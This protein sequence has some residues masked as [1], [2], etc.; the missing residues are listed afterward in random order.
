MSSLVHH[1][2]WGA[3]RQEL[4]PKE[5][6]I[7]DRC[8]HAYCPKHAV[9]LSILAAYATICDKAVTDVKDRALE[10]SGTKPL[11][12]F[13]VNTVRS[14]QLVQ[15]EMLPSQSPES[16]VK[17]AQIMK[18]SG[19][20]FAEYV[21]CINKATQLAHAYFETKGHPIFLYGS[22]KEQIVQWAKEVVVDMA[23]AAYLSV[24]M[25]ASF[26]KVSF[27]EE[28]LTFFGMKD[29]KVKVDPTSLSCVAFALLKTKEKRAVDL[30]FKE[31]PDRFLKNLIEHLTEWNYRPVSEPDEGDLV[32]Y[33]TNEN[34]VD[35]VGYL[36]AEGVVHSKIGI[37][38]PFSHHHKI[39]SIPPGSATVLFFRK[40]VPID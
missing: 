22:P 2:Q 26:E 5:L 38:N 31:C 32:L 18:I 17:V 25:R 35:H 19:I 4:T 24:G 13:R 27:L 12:G 20:T 23:N 9:A 16:I 33:L 3:I 6:I 40:S 37:R 29:K 28:E 21:E 36:S 34:D 10:M 14:I 15:K 7:K 1:A 39:F 30:I 8:F 11:G